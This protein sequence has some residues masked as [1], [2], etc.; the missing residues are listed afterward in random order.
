MTDANRNSSDVD[1]DALAGTPELG[2][3]RYEPAVGDK[4]LIESQVATIEAY[5][6]GTNILVYVRQAGNSLDRV[7]T[8]ISNTFIE[9]FPEA[10][11]SEAD[12]LDSIVGSSSTVS[13]GADQESLE[14]GAAR[15]SATQGNEFI[16]VDQAQH[17]ADQQA[18]RAASA[19]PAAQAAA[20]VALADGEDRPVNDADLPKSKNVS[21]DQSVQ[22][23]IDAVTDHGDD[24]D[25][26]DRLNDDESSK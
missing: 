10:R 15:V 5:D 17:L 23:N 2:D 24:E 4:V 18:D 13:N 7:T 19:Q 3:G 16:S 25:Q 6:R 21:D 20:E 26:S 11:Q 14:G 12:R 22:S 8:H 1:L 9:P